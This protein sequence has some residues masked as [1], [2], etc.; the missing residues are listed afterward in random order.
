MAEARVQAAAERSAANKTIYTKDTIDFGG[1]KIEFGYLPQAHTDGDIY[2][3]FR[4]ANVLVAGDVV[5][6]GAY[7]IIDYSTNGWLGGLTNAAQTL[8]DLSNDTTQGRSRA[9]AAC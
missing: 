6:S 5:S 2:V 8:F 4:N 3:Y 1:E 9:S 7:P